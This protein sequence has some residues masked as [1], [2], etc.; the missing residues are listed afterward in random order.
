MNSRS[1]KNKHPDIFLILVES[2]N[3]NHQSITDEKNR[4]VTPFLNQLS[5][6][7]TTID[8]FYGNSVQT[9]KGMAA[10]LF[11]SYPSFSGKLF[12][13]FKSL[14]FDSPFDELKSLGYA[15]LF[16]LGHDNLDYD[17]RREFLKK[18]RIDYTKT[19]YDDIDETDQKVIDNVGH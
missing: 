16:Y 9:A 12:T 8:Y 2:L 13:K 1:N 5:Q 4:P 6:T 14:T 11:S 19:V 15:S 10:T 18:H 3:Y 17:N 7:A